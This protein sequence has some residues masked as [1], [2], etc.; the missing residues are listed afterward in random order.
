VTSQGTLS[1][2]SDCPITLPELLLNNDVSGDNEFLAP[3]LAFPLWS[4]SFFDPFWHNFTFAETLPTT[5]HKPHS[6]VMVTMVATT[7]RLVLPY[8]PMHTFTNPSNRLG[9]YECLYSFL[10]RFFNSY[11]HPPIQSPICIYSTADAPTSATQLHSSC[12]DPMQ[13]LYF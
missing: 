13:V 5:N 9:I 6:I 7:D 4:L 12:H 8:L 1:K 10:N 3:S 2:M 11:T